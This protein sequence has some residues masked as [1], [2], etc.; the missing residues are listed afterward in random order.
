MATVQSLK[1]IQEEL[2]DFAKYYIKDSIY[3]YLDT[4][5]FDGDNIRFNFATPTSCGCCDDDIESE[6]LTFQNFEEFT[7][8]KEQYIAKKEE[9]AKKRKEQILEKEKIKKEQEK[10]T[11]EKAVKAL[12][13]K[14]KKKYSWDNLQ[15]LEKKMKHVIVDITVNLLVPDDFET[16]G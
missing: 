9:E 3:Q 16:V 8:N 5:E 10:K 4:V 2:N 13:E 7:N 11:Q 6:T 12:F 1:K 15:S 14:L